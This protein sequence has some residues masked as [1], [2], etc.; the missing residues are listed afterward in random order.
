MGGGGGSSG[1]AEKPKYG[2]VTL[3]TLGAT[4][5][6]TPMSFSTP[7]GPSMVPAGVQIGPPDLSQVANPQLP[8]QPYYSPMQN[9]Y[10][11]P[12]ILPGQDETQEKA[13]E[14]VSEDAS[15]R[16]FQPMPKDCESYTHKKCQVFLDW[17]TGIVCF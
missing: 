5:H 17:P 13:A 1:G 9:P 11:V 16:T 14:Y 10:G 7:G 15:T 4:V 2:P 8:Q 6:I 12:P 3:N